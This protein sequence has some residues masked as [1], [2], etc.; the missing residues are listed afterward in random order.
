M[1]KNSDVKFSF[2]SRPT[3]SEEI[4]PGRGEVRRTRAV[5]SMARVFFFFRSLPPFFLFLLF[6][7][8][9]LTYVAISDFC[10]CARGTRFAIREVL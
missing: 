4:L 2:P 10:V 8:P 5:T 3:G 7:S 1:R 9:S 6:S